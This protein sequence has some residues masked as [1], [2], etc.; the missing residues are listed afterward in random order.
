MSYAIYGA[1]IGGLSRPILSLPYSEIAPEWQDTAAPLA[2]LSNPDGC[3]TI[4]GNSDLYGLG[5][6]LGIYFQ[7]VASLL[8]NFY[9]PEVLKVGHASPLFCRGD[10]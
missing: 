3:L 10:F 8:A 4:L 5:I 1:V 9:H 2:L 7:I 6:R